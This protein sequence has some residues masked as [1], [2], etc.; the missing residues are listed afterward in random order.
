MTNFS[1]VLNCMRVF[2]GRF[3]IVKDMYYIVGLGNP[4]AQYEGTRHNCGF[5][6]VRAVVESAA[7]PELRTSARY[8]SLVTEGVWQGDTVTAV[9]PTT[10]MNKSGEAV[11][12]LVPKDKIGQLIVVY[13]EAALP[14]GKVRISVGGSAGG[15]NGVRSL[16]ERLGTDAFIRVRL[17]VGS[18]PDGMPL[19]RHVLGRFAPDEK[20]AVDALLALAVEAVELII[21]KGVTAA[22]NKVNGE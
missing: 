7:L 1:L 3:G 6:A 11:A 4:G 19:E 13:D 22:M 15:H 14:L 9:L 2:V 8:H 20:K 12:T 16:I 5:A 18:S 10:F 17:G 21:K